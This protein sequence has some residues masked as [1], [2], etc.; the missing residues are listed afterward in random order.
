MINQNRLTWSN[1]ENWQ[2]FIYE[3]ESQM[4]V[5]SLIFAPPSRFRVI[6]ATYSSSKI[7]VLQGHMIDLNRN[8]LDSYC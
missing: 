2:V 4:S 8:H 7:E 6:E 1:R 3:T 5:W